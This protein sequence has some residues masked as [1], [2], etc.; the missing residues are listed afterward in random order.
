MKFIKATTFVALSPLMLLSFFLING[1][2]TLQEALIGTGFSITLAVLFV[3][4]YLSDLKTLTYYVE[5]LALD[6]KAKAPELSFL[7]NVGMLSKALRKLNHSWQERKDQL[8]AYASENKVIIDT[9]QDPILLIDKEMRVLRVNNAAL[10]LLGSSIA[11]STIPEVID[12]KELVED[13]ST[14]LSGTEHLTMEIKLDQESDQ[15]Y[16]ANIEK[17]PIVSSEGIA[18]IIVLQNITES[19]RNET[20]FADFV[21]NASH[22]IRTPLTSIVGFIE[23]LQT[24]AKDDK[25]ARESFLGIMAEQADR[26]TKLVSDLLSLSKIEQQANKA[27]RKKIQIK[28]VI[29]S[30]EK[31]VLWAAEEKKISMKTRM[32]KNIPLIYGDSAELIQVICNILNNAIKYSPEKSTITTE[33]K[34]T[35]EFPKATRALKKA[36]KVVSIAIGDQGEGIPRKHLDR[37]T[38]RFYRVDTA[39]S[40]KEGG[41]GLGLAIVKHILKRHRGTLTIDSTIGKG[42]TFTIIL[43]IQTT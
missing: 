11:R 10:K 32:P 4:P 39:R 42:S 26:M 23:T 15:Y 12:S 5:Q 17:F 37:L 22:E 2:I 6:R 13:I 14:V 21:A 8:E 40:R 1:Q 34:V 30:A 18:A 27:P 7:S 28:N 3:T 43:P 41:N 33:V 31:Q 20:M 29:T 9:L 19:K 36:K 35:S 38:E 16:R 25:K 24:S